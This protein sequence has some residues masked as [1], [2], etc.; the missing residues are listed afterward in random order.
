MVRPDGR[1]SL[2][3]GSHSPSRVADTG[4]G[5]HGQ[6]WVAKRAAG[7]ACFGCCGCTVVFRVCPLCS[8]CQKPRLC[9]DGSACCWT[10]NLNPLR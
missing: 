9:G 1:R 2:A 7:H 6:R 10:Y 5:A 3:A 4:P 8:A